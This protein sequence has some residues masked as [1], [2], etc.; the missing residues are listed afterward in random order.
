MLELCSVT[1]KYKDKLALDQVSLKLDAGIYGLLGPNGAGKSTLMNLITGNIRPAGGEIKWEGKNIRDLGAT[2]RSLLGYATQQQGLYDNFT[3]RRFLAYMAALKGI[4]KKDRPGELRRVSE[5][6]NLSDV[7]DRFIGTYSGGMKQRILI[8]QAVLGDPEVI[9]LDEPTAGLDPR[10]GPYPGKNQGALRP[11][12]HYGVHPCGLGHRT[13]CRRDHFNQ[14]RKHC[15]P[16][17]G[18]ESLPEIWRCQ[19]AGR[20]LHAGFRR[21]GIKYPAASN[22]VS[23]LQRCRAESVQRK[24]WYLI[25]AAVAK[26]L[27]AATWLVARGNKWGTGAWKRREGT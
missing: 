8:A 4:S 16:G 23:N 18:G 6:V 17:Y 25:L 10:T 3:G 26:C 2:Y 22:G 14:V 21:N 12:D 1:K 5:F 24:L 7:A 15:G 19:R 11:P 20:S 27:Q 13:H 9:V